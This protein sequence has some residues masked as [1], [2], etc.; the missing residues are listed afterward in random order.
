MRYLNI[1]V[2]ILLS[3]TLNAQQWETLNKDCAQAFKNEEYQ[4][5]LNIGDSAVFI[6][7]QLFG[8][9]SRQRGE[10]L[11]NRAYAH[12]G[13]RQMKEALD[14]YSS[15]YVIFLGFNAPIDQ[16]EAANE[17]SKCYT[18]MG[19]LDSAWHYLDLAKVHL[20]EYQRVN[21]KDI[22]QLIQNVQLLNTEAVLN[23]KIGRQNEA[24]RLLQSQGQLLIDLYPNQFTFNRDFQ[25]TVNNLA[26]YYG[27]LGDLVKA[28]EYANDYL[29][30]VKD[31][32]NHLDHIY[33][34][35]NLASI[36]RNSGQFDLANS[37]WQEALSEIS[38]FNLTG[39][40]IHLVI[41]NNLGE[42]FIEVENYEKAIFYLNQAINYQGGNTRTDPSL[43]ETTRLNLA[44]ACHW[45]ESYLKADSLYQLIIY[46]LIDDIQSNFTYLSEDEKLAFYKNQQ[47][48]LDNYF[49]FALEI[50]GAVDLQNSDHPY[51]REDITKDMYNVQLATKGIILNSSVPMRTAITNSGNDE[52]SATFRQWESQKKKLSEAFTDVKSGTSFFYLNS[53]KH[54]VDSLEHW[55]NTHSKQFQK[56]FNSQSN[57]WD[58]IQKALNPGESV[59]EM[60]RLVDGL[61]YAA[62][63]LTPETKDKPALKLIF[64]RKSKHLEI[65]YFNNYSNSMRVGIVDTVSFSVYWSPIMAAISENS[66]QGE[67]PQRIYL[68]NDGVYNKINV[69]SLYDIDKKSFVIDQAQVVLVPNTGYILRKNTSEKK[70]LPKTATLLGNPSFPNKQ[71]TNLPGAESEVRDLRLLL[72]S[73]GWLVRLAIGAEATEKVIK[74]VRNQRVI[75]VASHGYFD[76]QQTYGDAS[77][78][79]LMIQ[80]GLVLAKEGEEDGFLNA[81]ELM[82]M[83]LSETELVVL[84]ACETGRG[85]LNSGEG[86][87]GLQRA[88]EIAGAKNCLMSLWKVDD[89]ATQQLMTEFY[90]YWLK[91]DNLR[92]SFEEAQILLRK[93]YPNPYFWGAFV[94]VGR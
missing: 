42:L 75:H 68:S 52:L 40:R 28:L 27:E 64:S 88:T 36:Y 41:L 85:V 65:E 73:K 63:I 19:Q 53:I 18:Q 7:I 81:Y 55:L 33:A 25:T 5:A 20:M 24:I 91:T 44:E 62:L 77:I 21:E 37:Y 83:D 1:F 78:A 22:D 56:G 48:I 49:G 92:Q 11:T 82:S 6:A 2:L 23:H 34:L 14:D 32:E 60:V 87:Y 3:T 8:E 80:S 61:V 86:V 13:L 84:S 58:Q 17:L 46:Q 74:E 93:E 76:P 26:S 10:S 16:S 50:C 69:N 4:K 94:L 29:N 71:F 79:Y 31:N 12:L 70:K 66:P 59:V 51:I 72:E 89:L 45:S 39:I 67:S 38:E 43:L 30:L 9:S 15:S 35:Q 57:T 90:K 47:S 54:K